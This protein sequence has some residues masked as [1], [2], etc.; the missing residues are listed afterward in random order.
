MKMKKIVS[1]FKSFEKYFIL[2]PS[3]I[4]FH[5]TLKCRNKIFF[6][7]FEYF[8][9]DDPIKITSDF[10]I[11]PGNNLKTVQMKNGLIL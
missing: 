9:L 1:K 11:H 7:D 3:D 2:S 8:G 4:G 6:I 5:N 10:I